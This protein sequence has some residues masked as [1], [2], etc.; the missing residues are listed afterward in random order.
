MSRGEK[1][2]AAEQKASSHHPLAHWVALLEEH[3]WLQSLILELGWW[4]GGAACLH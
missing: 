2:L 3:H 1:W 4:V